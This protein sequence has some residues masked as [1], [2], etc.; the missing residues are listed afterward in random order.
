MK[1]LQLCHKPP[2]PANDGGS[3]AMYNLAKGLTVNGCTVHVLAMNTHKQRC[4]PHEVPSPLQ[5]CAAYELV[6][7]DTRVK[8]IPA[9]LN[10]FSSESYNIIRFHSEAFRNKLLRLL[11]ANTY[12][13]VIL[14][15]LFTSTYIETIRSK[16]RGTIVLRAHNVEYCIWEN[17]AAHESNSLRRF[18]L[19]LL[20]RRLKKYETGT[21][22]AVDLIAAISKVDIARFQSDGCSTKCVHLPFGV[23][24]NEYVVDEEVSD[25]LKLFHVGSM[26]WRPHQEAFAWF[27]RN[28]W[29]LVEKQKV[30]PQLHLAGTGMPQWMLDEA[31]NH[32]FISPGT[33]DGKTFMRG[34]QVL[35]VPSFSGSGIRIKIIEAM[36]AGKVVITTANGA[37]G[38]DC[39]HG[40]N[41]LISEDPAE[42]QRF[43]EMLAVNREE[44]QRLKTNALKLIEE[45]HGFV[46][47]A[48]RLL[49]EIARR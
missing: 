26:N 1:I 44:F 17:L 40:E 42:W 45:Q 34:K 24:R 3:I 19:R 13:C 36:A 38:I 39:A 37:M 4:E 27:F 49:E 20:S 28:V 10:L 7:V 43:I 11:E 16:H 33:A 18:Y 15:S 46:R 31:D 6:E 48:H 9:F 25:E 23:D 2:Y 47:A 5:F 14:E 21:C 22:T 32:V 41:I 30:V 12:D 8:M 29:P 35:I